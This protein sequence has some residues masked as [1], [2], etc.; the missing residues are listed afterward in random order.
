M[1]LMQ[2]CIK[3]KKLTLAEKTQRKIVSNL[4]DIG[5]PI[6]L[7][8]QGIDEIVQG[9]PHGVIATA[10]PP[11]SIALDLSRGS[12]YGEDG[13]KV[14]AALAATLP[15]AGYFELVNKTDAFVCIKVL[16]TGGDRLWE[17]ARPSY[18]PIPPGDFVHA[19]F[20]PSAEA[21]ELYVLHNNP[22]AI[23]SD[24]PLLYDT[25]SDVRTWSLERI[26]VCARVSLFESATVYAIAC[27]KRNVLVKYKGEG[28]CEKRNGVA[29]GRVGMLGWLQAS[30]ND[31]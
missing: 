4:S 20:D 8:V 24:A 6:K 7:L 21:I 9:D 27:N 26:S 28:L 19:E 2:S 10:F 11:P 12:K 31:G 25:R 22:N 16:N 23:K 13:T 3:R 15:G 5:E 1:A 29:V 30:C 17:L 14:S 18:I